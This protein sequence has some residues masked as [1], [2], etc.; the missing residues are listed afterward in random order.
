MKRFRKGRVMSMPGGILAGVGAG[1]AAAMVVA[2]V[3]AWMIVTER[4]GESAIG[5]FAMAS[6]AIGSFVSCSISWFCLRHNRL[7]VVPITALAFYASL[8]CIGLA[9]GGGLAGFGTT[10][11]M[12][13]AGGAMSLIPA[14]IGSGSGAR[15]HKI[16]AYR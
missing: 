2:M 13:I 14:W 10:A 15:R 8:V 3:S 4:A 9:F 6:I 12:V 11:A 16:P 7:K 1:L 5:Y